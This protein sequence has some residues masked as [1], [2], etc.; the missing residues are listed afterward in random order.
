MFVQDAWHTFSRPSQCQSWTGEA[1]LGEPSCDAG[2]LCCRWAWG[3]PPWRK[4]SGTLKRLEFFLIEGGFIDAEIL[5]P[6]AS[7]WLHEY[8]FNYGAT[9]DTA[10]TSM[11]ETFCS[12]MC[13]LADKGGCNRSRQAEAVFLASTVPLPFSVSASPPA[14]WAQ[15]QWSD[16]TEWKHLK[17]W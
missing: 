11:Q 5:S 10:L 13:S 4:G 1:N 9:L 17:K 15:L 8:K 7:N 16:I 12:W 6:S 2:D 14:D 3:A